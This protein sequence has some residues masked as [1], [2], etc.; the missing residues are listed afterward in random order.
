MKRFTATV[1]AAAALGA[2]TGGLAAESTA[3]ACATLSQADAEK[4]LGGPVGAAVRFETKPNATNGGDHTTTCAYYFPKNYQPRAADR[5][6]ERALS[7]TLHVMPKPEAA[8]D[9]YEGHL[10]M[11]EEMTRQSGLP[12]SAVSKVSGIG[13]AAFSAQMGDKPAP[14][15]IVLVGFLRGRV[16]ATVQ[17]WKMGGSAEE[18]ARAAARQVVAKL[19]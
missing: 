18:A 12:A 14:A 6:P 15:S 16:L 4:L 1:L 19:P 7:I 3:T 5:P 17:A 13:E 11:Q 10:S 9:F 2:A 8:K